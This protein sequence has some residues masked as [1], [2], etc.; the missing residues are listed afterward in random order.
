MGVVVTDLLHYVD[1][2]EGMV[3]PFGTYHLSKDEVIAGVKERWGMEPPPYAT[4]TREDFCDAY[5]LAQMVRVEWLVR[6][7][8][9]DL[10]ALPEEDR[11]I[12][13]RV[14]P[15]SPVNLL[16]RPFVRLDVE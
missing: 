4:A 12:F 8:K 16:D 2:P 14:T 9:V 7:G 1:F 15:G 5:T 3:I 6:S 10:Q 11:R 13:L